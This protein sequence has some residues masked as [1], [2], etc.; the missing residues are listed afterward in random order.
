M[1]RRRKER[2]FIAMAVGYRREPEVEAQYLVM[3]EHS[4]GGGRTI[5]VQR[6]GAEASEGD[7][8]L[9][10]GGYCL[11]VDGGPASCQCVER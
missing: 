3:A 1:L 2:R 6:S 5:E 4:D 10:V 8:S 9:S 7:S 11:V